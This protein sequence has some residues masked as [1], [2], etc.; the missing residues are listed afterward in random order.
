MKRIVILSVKIFILLLVATVI[1]SMIFTRCNKENPN[2]EEKPTS[3][4]NTA[5]G[6]TALSYLSEKYGEEFII[7]GE[8]QMRDSILGGNRWYCATVIKKS[9]ENNDDARTYEVSVTF[10]SGVYTVEGDTFMFTY[11][12]KLA[13]EHL[14]PIVSEHISDIPYELVIIRGNESKYGFSSDLKIPENEEDL[15]QI[16][17]AGNL[18]ITFWIMVPLSADNDSMTDICGSLNDALKESRFKWYGYIDIIDDDS[19][20]KIK[21]SSDP[22]VQ[23]VQKNEYTQCELYAV[24]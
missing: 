10:D 11:I 18:G 16:Q 2:P 6:E 15:Y 3:I 12:Q 8:N 23:V 19:F 24:G 9:D 21:E 14:E 20:E 1:L 22:Y 5:A 13:K 4:D 7:I 17:Y